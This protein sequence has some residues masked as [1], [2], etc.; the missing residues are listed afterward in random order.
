MYI[1]FAQNRFSL[2]SNLTNPLQ[3]PTLHLL[4]S[5]ATC[6]SLFC[7]SLL[8]YCCLSFWI[9]KLYAFISFFVVL[10]NIIYLLL[11]SI[12]DFYSFC[13]YFP[14]CA[15]SYWYYNNVTFVFRLVKSVSKNKNSSLIP[16]NPSNLNI[17]RF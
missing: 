10:Y 7:S 9:S 16:K 13:I 17:P 2:K 1:V 8:Y 15:F 4:Y 14:H 6:P 3:W 11:H 12:I 5:R